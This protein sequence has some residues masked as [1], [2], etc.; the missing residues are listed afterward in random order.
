MSYVG[1][2]PPQTTIPADDSV[3]SAMIVDGTIVNADINAS[4][5]VE[6][7]KMATD[8]TNASNLASGTVPTARLGSGSASSSTFLTGAQTYAA[9][10]TS[11]ITANQDDIALLGFKVAANGSLAKYDLV[12]QTIDAFEDASGVDASASTNEIRDSS[13]YYSGSAA[14]AILNAYTSGSGN[15]TAGAGVTSVEVVVVAGGG[16]GGGLGGGGGAGGVVHHTG[17]TVV[18]TNTYAYSVGTGGAGVAYNAGTAADGGNS[19]F[20]TGTV[21]TAEGG[22]GASGGPASGRDG[23]SGGAGNGGYAS[24]GGASDQPAS[25]GGGTGYGNDG[26]DGAGGAYYGGGGGGLHSD[27]A[28]GGL[29]TM[30]V[31]KR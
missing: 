2:K 9:V 22:G 15:F 1:N 27:Y 25:S 7:S 11:G 30:F 8:T 29:I 17:Y 4:A 19:T 14:G 28:D 3:T 21:M 10:D 31:E 5:G 13:K 12:D 18:P 23:G 6:N 16:G 26:G 20:G 24:P